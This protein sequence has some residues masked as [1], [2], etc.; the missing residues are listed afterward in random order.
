MSMAKYVTCSVGSFV[1][2]TKR[3][4]YDFVPALL[5]E[6]APTKATDI[7]QS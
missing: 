7:E 3:S 1:I 6:L 2:L 4:G 5:M